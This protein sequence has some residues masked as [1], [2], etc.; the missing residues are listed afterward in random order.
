MGEI[1]KAGWAESGIAALPD[2]RSILLRKWGYVGVRMEKRVGQSQELLRSLT[3]ALYRFANE[4]TLGLC[5]KSG[6]LV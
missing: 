2:S 4:V 6:K 1:G 5:P 3:P